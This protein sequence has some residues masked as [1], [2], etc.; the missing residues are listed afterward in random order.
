MKGFHP[1][2]GMRPMRHAVEKMIGDAVA[3]HVLREWQRQRSPVVDEQTETLV[4]QPK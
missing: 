3:C 1:K 4:V 2:L